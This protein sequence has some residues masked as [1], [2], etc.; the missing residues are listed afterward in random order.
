LMPNN[1]VLII[2]SNKDTLDF[3]TDMLIK[4]GFNK[5]MGIITG[6]GVIDIIDEKN[7]DS[8]IL[9]INIEGENPI[10][11]LFK[12]KA[13]YPIMPVIILASPDH[14]DIAETAIRKGASSYIVYKG[15]GDDISDAIKTRIQKHKREI[16]RGRCDILVVDDDLEISEMIQSYLK[17]NGYTC[18][19]VNN[20]DKAINKLLSSKPKL[21]LLD[22]VMPRTDGIALLNKIKK[23]D[24]TIKVIMMSGVSDHDIC[25]NAIKS[26]ASGYITKPFSLQQLKVTLATTLLV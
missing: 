2:D 17:S 7:P 18:D 20:P 26:G 19:V 11:I 10:D 14:I 3:L 16:A 15:M 23:T 21:V 24:L 25:I 13:N 12:I 1:S 4:K 22:I 8:I 9:N 5:S 6:E